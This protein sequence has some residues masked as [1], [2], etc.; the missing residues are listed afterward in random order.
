[1]SPPGSDLPAAIGFPIPVRNDGTLSLPLIKPLP[2]RGLTLGQVED[3]IRNAYTK[4]TKTLEPG[5]DRII[6]TLIRKRT[7]TVVVI[8]RDTPKGELQTHVVRLEAYK[9]DVLHALAATGGLPH[10]TSKNEVLVVRTGQL[11][12]HKRLEYLRQ[13][14]SPSSDQSLSRATSPDIPAMLRIPLR[15]RPGE[16]PGIGREQ[17]LL[18]DQDTIVI[19]DRKEEVFYTGGKL[20]HGVYPLPRDH[21]IDVLSAISIARPSFE[22]GMMGQLYILR[23]TPNK[24]EITITVDLSRAARDTAARPIL[25]PGDT[26]ILQ[27]AEKQP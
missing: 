22:G 20:G 24:G 1:V 13:Y 18:F 14:L 27:D 2:V 7:T 9:N 8:R 16:S 17:V 19:E 10:V 26:L 25:Q 15:M 3:A 23:K 21:D 5:R 6:V 4:G 11:E 12:K